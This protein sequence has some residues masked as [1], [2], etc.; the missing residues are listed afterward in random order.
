MASG[1]A[2]RMVG[3]IRRLARRRGGIVSDDKLAGVPLL[4]TASASGRTGIYF[5]PLCTLLAGVIA[6]AP[7]RSVVSRWLSRSLTA[8]F[9]CLSLYFMLC[10]R[11]SYFREYEWNA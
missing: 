1:C 5:V 11:L 4:R 7:P 8:A 10:L 2:R 6:A 9:L 3:K